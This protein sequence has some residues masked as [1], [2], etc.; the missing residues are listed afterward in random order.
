MSKGRKILWCFIGVLALGVIL[1]V[2]VFLIYRS[3]GQGRAPTAVSQPAATPESAA[4]PTP[5]PTPTP[6]PTPTPEPTLEPYFPPEELLEYHN[7]NEHV[8]GLLDIPGTSVHYPIL[9]HPYEDNYYLNI[10]IDGNA[11]YPGSIYTNLE[12]GQ[13]FETFNTVIYG[14]NMS[15]GSMFADLHL[16]DNIEFMKT[17]RTLTIYS[18]TEK[19]DYIICATIIYDDRYITYTY[20]DAIE[21]DCSAYLRSL[22]NG[23]WM[24]DVQVTT[25]SHIVTLS[26]C[27][28]GMPDNRRLLIAVEQED[29]QPDS[30]L[31]LPTAD[32]ETVFS[33][34]GGG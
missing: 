14:H 27:I 8:I 26:T 22:Q 28:G 16:F 3:T 32:T 23:I 30:L 9:Q 21:E 15:D 24:D 7:R 2:S 6:S 19:H 5:T 10:T 33:S 20:N 29:Q 12:E 11:G 13:N 31:V 4:A 1:G 18:M 17:H 34:S 25:S